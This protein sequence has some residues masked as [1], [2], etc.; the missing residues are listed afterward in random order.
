MKTIQIKQNSQNKNKLTVRYA[1][2][3]T[4]LKI[5]TCPTYSDYYSLSI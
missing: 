1:Q 3:Y 2:I 5:P 4:P